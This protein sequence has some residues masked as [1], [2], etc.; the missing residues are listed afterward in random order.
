MAEKATKAV[1]DAMAVAG[2]LEKVGQHRWAEIVRRVCR[3]NR[4]YR[5]T[6]QSLHRDN[7]KLR[8]D[9]RAMEVQHG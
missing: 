2:E 3:G 7:M 6:L 9:L 8:E 5:T 4:S 1:D